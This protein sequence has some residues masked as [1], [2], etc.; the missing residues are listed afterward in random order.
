MEANFSSEN[1]LSAHRTARHC[2]TENHILINQLV[3]NI[4][5]PFIVK[6]MA[7][8]TELYQPRCLIRGYPPHILSF[9][10]SLV[11][12]YSLHL[13]L[14]LC[15]QTSFVCRLSLQEQVTPTFLIRL[16]VNY[17]YKKGTWA[18]G[19]KFLPPPNSPSAN[20]FPHP[21]PIPGADALWP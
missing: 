2:K 10:S 5:K 12:F 7:V 11:S 14:S 19:L 15:T 4:S 16:K 13:F 20:P 1:S 18:V 6:K 3:V 9:P 17:G 8:I 21:S